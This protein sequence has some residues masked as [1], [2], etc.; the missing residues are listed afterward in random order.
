MRIR[1]LL[2]LFLFGCRVSCGGNT[3]G[4][5]PPQPEAWN[6]R[7]R[8]NARRQEEWT[9]ANRAATEQGSVQRNAVGG[10][11]PTVVAGAAGGIAVVGAVAIVASQ[12]DAGPPKKAMRD[13]PDGPTGG[14]TP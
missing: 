1:Y 2:L 10:L 6:E 5:P 4:P 12:G 13:Q 11:S 9:Q 14:L 3:K 8:E 7:D